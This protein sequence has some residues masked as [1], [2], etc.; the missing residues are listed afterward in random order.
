MICVLKATSDHFHGAVY[1]K[2][3]NKNKKCDCSL[4]M[5]DETQFTLNFLRN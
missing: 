2:G 3:N 4:K 5:A 1:C